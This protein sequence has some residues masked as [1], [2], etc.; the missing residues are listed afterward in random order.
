MFEAGT[1]HLSLKRQESLGSHQSWLNDLGQH[2]VFLFA[3][4]H[5]SHGI[6]LKGQHEDLCLWGQE[7][8]LQV[9]KHGPNVRET[10]GKE[11]GHELFRVF[12][13]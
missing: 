11:M 7:S 12:G 9:L 8:F 5:L 3:V 2:L 6:P 4:F 1:S 10:L 13:V